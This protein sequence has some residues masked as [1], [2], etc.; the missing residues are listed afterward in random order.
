MEIKFNFPEDNSHISNLA[1]VKALLIKVTID[2]LD[3]SYEQKLDLK[4][5][6]L[7]YLK[8]T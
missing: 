8:K 1:F 2:N 3:V 6:I 5:K 4:N 7:E